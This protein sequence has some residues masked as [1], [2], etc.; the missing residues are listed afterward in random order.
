MFAICTTHWLQTWVSSCPLWGVFG[1]QGPLMPVQKVYVVTGVRSGHPAWMFFG[2]V[3]ISWPSSSIWSKFSSFKEARTR[4]PELGMESEVVNVSDCFL[5]S[6]QVGGFG[7]KPHHISHHLPR[8]WS[9]AV[10]AECVLCNFSMKEKN[11]SWHCRAGWHHTLDFVLHEIHVCL[12]VQYEN[13]Q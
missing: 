12:K 1:K 5:S 9:Q 6:C 10:C 13:E 4:T 8:L 11:C 3:L 7:V 2:E